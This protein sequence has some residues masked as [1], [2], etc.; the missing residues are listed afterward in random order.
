MPGQA[1][2]TVR[3]PSARWL[4][5]AVIELEPGERVYAT[6]IPWAEYERLWSSGTRTDAASGSRWIAETWNWTCA[7]WPTSPGPGGSNWIVHELVKG[8]NVPVLNAGPR[9]LF[10]PE[11]VRRARSR[12][13]LLS[14]QNAAA[15]LDHVGGRAAMPPPDLVI[16]V[17]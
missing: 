12:Q 3:V 17:L 5:S 13:L 6:G 11:E 10:L 15:A 14:S 8:L 1:A 2:T 9:M 4:T 7:P 16:R